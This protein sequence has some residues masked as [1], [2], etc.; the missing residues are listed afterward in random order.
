MGSVR[1]EGRG[2][3]GVK[4]NGRNGR[5]GTGRNQINRGL[6]DLGIQ[7]WELDWEVRQK[8]SGGR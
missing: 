1:G 4:F 6:E 3:D 2:F 8:E 7:E 5:W